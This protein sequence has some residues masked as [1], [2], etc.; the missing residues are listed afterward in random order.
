MLGCNAGASLNAGDHNVLL[1]R[2]AGNAI[3]SGIN[4]LAIGNNAGLGVVDG[5]YNLLFGK[6]AGKCVTSGS[7]NTFFGGNGPGHGTASGVTGSHNYAGGYHA[8]C[9][10]TSGSCNIVI[11]KFAGKCITTGSRNIA[12]GVDALCGG[13]VTGCNNVAIGLYAGKNATSGS[14]NIILGCKAGSCKAVTGSRN[15]VLGKCA[16]YFITCGFNNV[17]IGVEA[18]RT[19][20][21]G[22]DNVSIGA[23]TGP[24]SGNSN[25]IFGVNTASTMTGDNN[26]VMGEF[27]SRKCAMSGDHNIVMGDC[28]GCMMTSANCNIVMGRG[29][30]RSAIFTGDD[31]II[32]GS[33]SAA[34]LTGGSCNIFMGYA[35]GGTASTGSRN[36]AIGKEVDPPAAGSNDTLAIGCGASRWI[37]GDSSFN[38]T[39]AGI[40][41]TVFNSTNRLHFGD[42]TCAVFGAGDDLQIFHNNAD[43]II[44]HNNATTGND[45]LIQSDT[46]TIFSNV[47]GSENHAIFNDDGAVELF[48]NGNPKLNTTTTGVGIASDV[49]SPRANL[50]VEGSVHATRFFQ[51][52]TALDTTTS[53][54]ADGG[55]AVN[56]GVYGPYTINTGV[57]LTIS[58]G[59]TFTVV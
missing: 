13:N 10:I 37:A 42:Q 50:H 20:C 26:I 17:F 25:I 51:N 7:H 30:G 32:F 4:N 35:S 27:A 16:G 18:A 2:C 1:G 45:L 55:A 39:L 54:P 40:A 29:A 58:D 41:L 56:G 22:H 6:D 49:T 46:K 52:P 5:T 59:S 23:S 36:I 43:S 33:S 28:A 14:D 3:T 24:A 12:F 11:G 38:V 8:A 47:G 9:F 34:A 31:N 21:N 53:F 57:T 48:H 15:V 19:Y 44:K